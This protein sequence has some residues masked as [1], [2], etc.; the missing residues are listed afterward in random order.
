[1]QIPFDARSELPIAIKA[2]LDAGKAVLDVYHT[3]FDV[4]NADKKFPVTKADK[5]SHAV[6]S[7]A[8]VDL[9]YPVISEEGVMHISDEK[10]VWIVD[11]LDGTSDFVSKTG[12]FTIMIAL[13]EKHV[14]V[15]GVIY[16]PVKNELFV[17]EKGK[18]A[19]VLAGGKWSRLQVSS[20]SDIHKTRLLASRHH[21]SDDEKK[22]IATLWKDFGS[23]GSSL[24]AMQIV[25]GKADL[26][27]TFGALRQWDTCASTCILTEAGGKATDM[28][29]K[30]LMYNT[31]E[32]R[33]MNGV[34]MSNWKVHDTVVRKYKEFHA[35]S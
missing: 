5:E 35:T 7:S 14:P 1:M 31:T 10:T 9:G 4:L 22:F 3:D 19:Y 16:W 6:I 24:K 34:L 12:E 26:Y 15:M 8:L 13:V 32:I 33:H 21:L 25:A 23:C 17:A 30:P 27:F 2:A 18:G 28:L 29:G 20:V 11:P